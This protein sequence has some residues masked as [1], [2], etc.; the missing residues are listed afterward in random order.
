MHTMQTCRAYAN[1]CCEYVFLVMVATCCALFG[2]WDFPGAGGHG[3]GTNGIVSSV[4]RLPTSKL[5][6]GSAVCIEAR[7]LFEVSRNPARRRRN[8][9]GPV[10]P[11]PLTHNLISQHPDTEASGWVSAG[12]R[13]GSRLPTQNDG[14]IPRPDLQRTLM[15]GLSWVAVKELELSYYNGYLWELI[16]FPQYS[17]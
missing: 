9:L 16:L 14:R 15:M 11:K 17:N 7:F 3:G 8:T 13:S 10:H 12:Q 5:L 6:G 4:Q 2:V 1:T